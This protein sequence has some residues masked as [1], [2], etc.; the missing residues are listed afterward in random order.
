VDRRKIFILEAEQVLK[1]GYKERAHDG[2]RGPGS[3]R[4]QDVSIDPDSKIDIL[5]PPAEIKKKV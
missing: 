5:D 4:R 1:V 2:F 3:C